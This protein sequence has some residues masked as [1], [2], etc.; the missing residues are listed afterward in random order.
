VSVEFFSPPFVGDNP[1]QKL[2][3]PGCGAPIREDS[4]I[5]TAMVL[6]DHLSLLGTEWQFSGDQF[7]AVKR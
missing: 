6:K 5:T 7:P 2:V 4:N 1:S 3:F